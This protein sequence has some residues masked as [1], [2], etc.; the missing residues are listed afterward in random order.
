M[1]VKGSG[2]ACRWARVA[3]WGA[4]AASQVLR[5]GQNLSIFP[6]GRWVG[7]LA[8]LLLDPRRRSSASKPLRPPRPPANLVV[9]TSPFSVNVEAG[10]PWPA[11]ADRNSATTVGPL[12]WRWA[13]MRSR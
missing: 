10:I 1:L 3:G 9:N 8:V 11:T 13:V 2:N 7:A 6:L 12:M 4:W 5:V